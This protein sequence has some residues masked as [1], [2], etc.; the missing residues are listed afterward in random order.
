[1]AEIAKTEVYVLTLSRDELAQINTVLAE[2]TNDHAEF[3]GV[4]THVTDAISDLMDEVLEI[5]DD[6]A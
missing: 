2:L 6:E 4:D 3:I 5:Y 1:M